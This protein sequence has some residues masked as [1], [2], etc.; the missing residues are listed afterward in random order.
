MNEKLKR[1]DG[2]SDLGYMARLYRDKDELGL[3]NNKEINEV[4]NR[5]LDK[6]IAESTGRCLSKAY[7][8][9]RQETLDE[10]AK[11]NYDDERMKELEEKKLEIEKLVV[12]YQDQKREYKAYLRMDARWEHLINE[13]KISI[14]KNM[15]ESRI[16]QPTN[17]IKIIGYREATLVLSDWHIGM[18]NNSIHNV[19]NIE[20]AKER[21]NK[22]YNKVFC[23]CQL[24]E[25]RKLHIEICGDM[26][27]GL[28]HLG[29]RI[30]S[31]EDS[32]SQTMI[33][34]EMLSEL[35]ANFANKIE[36][37]A[38]Y[39]CLGNHS[40]V[41]ANIKDSI[42]VENFER[43]ITWYMKPR[44]EK[45]DNVEIYDNFE[46]D[47]ILYKVF[48]LQ[49]ASV[50]G[51]KEKYATAISDMSNFLRIFIDELHLGHWH[52]HNV[53]TDNDMVTIVNGSFGGADEYAESIRK[54]NKPS[55]TLIIYNEEGQECLYNIKL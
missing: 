14:K 39:G 27:H 30:N 34:S 16:L 19:Y 28:I 11:E 23:Y 8:Q 50:H 2:E 15:S 35:V 9:G 45:F 38:V 25:V 20:I 12:Q 5:E 47:I 53:K 13:M 37:V 26:V 1:R 22:L 32:I 51:H 54:S 24:H 41:S 43:M 49:I 44:L 10:M 29:T 7:N 33:V 3:G 55:Q 18:E 4:I 36:K 31:E 40:R 48:D 17:E 21:M 52:S 46:D 6:K 42:E